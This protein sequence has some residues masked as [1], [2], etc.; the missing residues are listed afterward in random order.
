M[1]KDPRKTFANKIAEAGVQTPPP[2]KERPTMRLLICG[3]RN[4]TDRVMIKN[5]LERVMKTHKIIVIEGEANGADKLA[6]MAARQL[7]LVVEPYPADWATYGKAA[8]PIRN[9][10]MLDE[11]KPHIV[12]AY[13]DNIEASKGTKDMIQRAVRAGISVRIH[14]HGE[15]GGCATQGIEP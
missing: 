5:N 1:K 8:G 14:S 4:W 2:K 13:H 3:D 12:V 10:K 7:G 11:G 15:N 9:Q 6:A